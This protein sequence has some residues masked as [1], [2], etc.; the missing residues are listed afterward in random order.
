MDPR[1][2]SDPRRA[3][4]PERV[5][6]RRGEADATPC[7]DWMEEVLMLGGSKT[8]LPYSTNCNI[9]IPPSQDIEHLKKTAVLGVGY[10]LI[11]RSNNHAHF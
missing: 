10:N 6:G 4:R 3:S 2:W 5:G 7:F 11:R 8:A 9:E 1:K